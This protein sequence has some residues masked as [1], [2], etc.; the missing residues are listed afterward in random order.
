MDEVWEQASG[1]ETVEVS[2]LGRVKKQGCVVEPKVFP[3]SAGYPRISAEGL[4]VRVHRLVA[5]AFLGEPDGAKEVNHING[6]KTDNQ[7]ENLEWVTKA[8]NMEHAHEQGL[9]KKRG[10][11]CNWAQLSAIE[12]MRVYLL[13]QD[14]RMHNKE[15]AEH[16]GV[17][18]KHVQRIANHK[19]WPSLHEPAK[20]ETLLSEIP[21]NFC[22]EVWKDL[23]TSQ[24][25]GVSLTKAEAQQIY[26]LAHNSDLSY[27][28]IAEKFEVHHSTVSNIKNKRSWDII[29]D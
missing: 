27:R 24:R 10:E 18:A 28:E 7:I 19:R 25:K 22:D 20:R 4:Q 3:S 1:F 5:K 29:H 12:A 9:T 13:T 2:S 8:E 21:D 16:F 26:N 17:S 6:D 23:D 15:I 14:G 11:H